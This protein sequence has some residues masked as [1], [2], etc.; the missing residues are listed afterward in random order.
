MKTLLITIDL[1]LVPLPIR[2]EIIGVV[3]KSRTHYLL[4]NQKLQ[5]DNDTLKSVMPTLEKIKG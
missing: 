5:I 2:N 1:S 4:E 3:K